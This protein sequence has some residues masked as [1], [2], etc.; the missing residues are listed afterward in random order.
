MKDKNKTRQQL[1]NE[2]AEMRQQIAEL[3]VAD[4]EHKRVENMLHV[5]HQLGVDL[6]AT[7]DITEALNKI[8]STAVQIEGV[9]CG[10][11]YLIDH[12]SGDVDLIV[13]CG[14]PPRFVEENSHYS[15]NSPNAQLV[16]AG[17]PVYQSFSDFPTPIKEQLQLEGLGGLAVVPIKYTGEDGRRRV[18]ACL[19]LASH[20]YN[21]IPTVTRDLIETFAIEIGRVVGRLQAERALRE[22]EERYRLLAENVTDVIWTMDMD[23]RYTYISPS[24]ERMRGYSVDE[25]MAQSLADALCP[26]S[27]EVALQAYEEELAIEEKEPKDLLRTRTMELQQKCKDG[28]TIWVEVTIT[29]LHNADGQ[30]VGILGVSRDTSEHRRAEEERERLIH[31]LERSNA[32]L[33]QFAYV[34]SHD[35]Q[36]PLRMVASYT[37]L[38]EKRYKGNLDADADEFIAYAVDGALRM[39]EIIQ[40]LLYFSRVGSQGNP[41]QLTESES[42]FKQAMANMKLAIDESGAEMTHDPLPQV[43]ADETQLIQLFQNLLANAIKFRRK[44]QP[45][46][47]VSAKQ[48]ENE[49]LFSVSD[50]GIGLN[51]EYFDRIFVIFQRLHGREEYSG[52]GIGLSICKRIVERHGGRIWV[53]SQP[54]EGSTFYFTIPNGG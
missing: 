46:I 30:P 20:T 48:D 17:E 2:L 40:S 23:L 7:S 53:E 35:L 25:A 4:T 34:A 9:D 1:I 39:Q 52:T 10:G 47:H 50:N 21:E 16:M 27:L 32:E 42:A 18:I 12:D 49:S 44:E 3:E 45:R 37:Q 14:L 6:S 24:V 5:Q 22:S 43:K 38:L 41:L 15:V 13:H 19:N 28:S 36:E 31:E 51:P 29:F 26:G 33:Q 11:V 54:G 8:L